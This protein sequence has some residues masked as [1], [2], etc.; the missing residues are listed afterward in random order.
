MTTWTTLDHT[1]V[2]HSD[3]ASHDDSERLLRIAASLANEDGVFDLND[4]KQELRS[5]DQNWWP[6]EQRL[7][8]TLMTVLQ[9]LTELNPGATTDDLR[10]ELRDL[11]ASE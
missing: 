1:A 9:E 2:L 11:I 10:R 6:D 3:A 7:P 4:L 5:D 8:H